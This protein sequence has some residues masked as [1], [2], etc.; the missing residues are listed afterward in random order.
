KCQRNT[1]QIHGDNLSSKQSGPYLAKGAGASSRAW[2]SKRSI[3]EGEDR[4]GRVLA[5]RNFHRAGGAGVARCD[6]VLAVCRDRQ[7]L[8]LIVRQTEVVDLVPAG[9]EGGV[10]LAVL[11]QQADD[12]VL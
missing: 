7:A 12:G 5:A 8:E 4:D 10:G 11:G 2:F 6:H 3:L 1:G 9:A